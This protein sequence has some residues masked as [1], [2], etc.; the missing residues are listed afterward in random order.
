MVRGLICRKIGMTRIYND[1]G[2][3]VPVTL[4]EAGPCT[5]SAVRTEEADGYNAVQLGF[6]PV[7][8]SKL[9]E[10]MKGL[11]KKR[12][13]SPFKILREFR[14]EKPSELKVGD[15]VTVDIF[16][17][18]TKV[19]V[20]G[21]SKGAGFAG[22]V[23]RHGFFGAPMSHGASKVHRKPMSAGATD[24]ARVFKGKRSP[25]HMG[26]HRVTVRN[27]TVVTVDAERNLLALKGAVPGKKNSIL[28]VHN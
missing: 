16:K 4:V 19:K 18:N 5:V 17:E 21:V 3:I 7:V 24:A 13:I 26:D 9:N 2:N 1:K 14:T 22:A 11:F 15:S 8:E 10:P 6:L 23:K 12:G 25:G 28:I 20:V 27:L